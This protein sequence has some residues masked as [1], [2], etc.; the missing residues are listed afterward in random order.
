MMY[1]NLPQIFRGSMEL[2]LLLLQMVYFYC[3]CQSIQIR[4]RRSLLL[5]L[6]LSGMTFVLFQGLIR[7]DKG[8]DSAIVRLRLPV[9]LPVIAGWAAETRIASN[10]ACRTAVSMVSGAVRS[11]WRRGWSL[12]SSR[13]ISRRSMN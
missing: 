5:V 1:G 10:A 12:K 11:R 3:L 7:Y 4:N 2:W 9:L 8:V 6:T 13:W